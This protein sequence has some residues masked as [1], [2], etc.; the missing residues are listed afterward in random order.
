MCISGQSSVKMILLKQLRKQEHVLL[1]KSYPEN[2]FMLPRSSNSHMVSF[3]FIAP[4][5]SD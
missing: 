2:N 5:A 3:L 1:A 4:E